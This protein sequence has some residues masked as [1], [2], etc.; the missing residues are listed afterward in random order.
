MI[1]YKD[2]P[3]RRLQ[4]RYTSLPLPSYRFIPGQTPHPRKSP[5]GFWYGQ[6]EPVWPCFLPEHWFESE[7]YVYGL[8][9]FNATL[10]WESHEQWESL[11]RTL[12]RDAMPAQF[13][14]GLIQLAAAHLRCVMGSFDGALR[15]WQRAEENFRCCP[16]EY[17][18]LSLSRVL[19]EAHVYLKHDP[20]ISLLEP[21]L[22]Q[23]VQHSRTSTVSIRI[24]FQ[25]E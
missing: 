3:I 4:R 18:G 12:P 8:D 22:L 13:L 16:D 14:R 23:V 24:S 21:T 11:W 6:P 2:I 25:R 1:E 17:C 19:K 20:E 10:W 7:G 15:L 5:E 9:L